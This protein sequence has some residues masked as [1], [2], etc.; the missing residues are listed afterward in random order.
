[1]FKFN[2]KF[3]KLINLQIT[4][5]SEDM[6]HYTTLSEDEYSAIKE[7]LNPYPERILE[8]GCGLGRMSIFLNRKHPGTT[9][10]YLADTSEISEKNNMYGWNPGTWYND[11]SLT[12]EFCDL[13]GLTNYE[14]IDLRK[15]ELGEL[16]NIDLV[17]SFMSV[18][19]HYPLEEYFDVLKSV[20]NENGTMIFGVRRGQY[21][22][23]P[24]LSEFL[25]VKFCDIPDQETE[26]ILVLKGWK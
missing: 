7:Y 16:K 19:F 11:L 20:L 26:R 24:I 1:M 2:D 23:S 9:R 8:I 14:I 5:T 13:N 18:G 3:R 12:K 4:T 10:Y 22:N 25:F 6:T 21:E 15:E 17:Y